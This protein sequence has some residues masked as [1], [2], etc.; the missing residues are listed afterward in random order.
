MV[1][2][3]MPSSLF[4]ESF[5]MVCLVYQLSLGGNWGTCPTLL[6]LE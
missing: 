6:G 3:A 1:G 4:D 2:L 5:Q